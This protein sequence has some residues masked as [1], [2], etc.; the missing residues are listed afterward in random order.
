M[1]E[2]A[3]VVGLFVLL[4][5]GTV[6]TF[7]FHEI[8]RQAV[9]AARQASWSTTWLHDRVS[10]EIV[11]QQVRSWHFERAGWMD[12]TGNEAMPSREDAVS[13]Q[14]AQDAP[15]GSAPAAV[16]LALQ[17]LRAVGGFLG[18]GFDLPMDRYARAVLSV[19]V[20]PVSRLPEP[21]GSMRLEL[22][23]HLGV[24]GDPWMATGPSEVASRA[25]GLVPTGLLAGRATW[26]RPVLWPLTVLEPAIGKLCL[27]L[28][29]PDRV[30]ADRLVG[31][32]LTGQQPGV[33][34]CH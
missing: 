6:L 30:P 12:P 20:E 25:G 23:E 5:L 2:F 1:T 22:T 8:Q 16:D 21:L 11:T 24:L 32:T 17:P 29:E 34:G 31:S 4:L 26:L 27:G 10:P 28:I 9:L 33:S 7:R 14:L 15:P 3:I 13:V 18:G 19:S